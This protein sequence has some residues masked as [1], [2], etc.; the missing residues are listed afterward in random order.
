MEI[1][2]RIWEVGKTGLLLPVSGSNRTN[3]WLDD[4]WSSG[5][6][7]AKCMDNIFGCTGDVPYETCF[8][9]L[10]AYKSVEKLAEESLLDNTKHFTFHYYRTEPS[11]TYSAKVFGVVSLW[12]KI[13]E[14][15]WGYRAQYGKVEAIIYVT[16]D[17]PIFLLRQLKT[18]YTVPFY[19]LEDPR[20]LIKGGG[21]NEYRKADQDYK[22]TRTYSND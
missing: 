14:H 6:A 18:N 20:D 16:K 22:R 21:F 11:D 10:Y 8:C 3:R 2:Y 5:I 17:I 7:K 9:G 15:E 1:G 12:G 19:P 13:I 4:I